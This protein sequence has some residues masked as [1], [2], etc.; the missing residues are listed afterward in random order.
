M[1]FLC[2]MWVRNFGLKFDFGRSVL[3]SFG[4]KFRSE[5]CITENPLNDNFADFLL[6]K[7]NRQQRGFGISL[8]I[9]PVG[10]KKTRKMLKYQAPNLI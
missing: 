9:T 3:H 2:E 8:A 1:V 7:E 4:P 10:R 5:I 6:R